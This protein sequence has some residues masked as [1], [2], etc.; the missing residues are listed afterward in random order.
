MLEEDEIYCAVYDP[1]ATKIDSKNEDSNSGFVVNGPAIIT[2]NPCLDPADIRKVNCICAEEMLKRFKK[3]D[4][5][6][7]L[8]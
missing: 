8:F 6:E 1:F 4:F 5:Q 2:R 7:N 3:K